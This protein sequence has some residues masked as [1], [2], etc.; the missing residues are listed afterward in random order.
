MRPNLIVPVQMTYGSVCFSF[1]HYGVQVLVGGEKERVREEARGPGKQGTCRQLSDDVQRDRLSDW[2][3][4]T[5]RAGNGFS[6]SR[7][8]CRRLGI[9]LVQNGDSLLDI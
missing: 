8:R 1:C 7:I 4:E 6:G 9:L 5:G 3:R 2:T